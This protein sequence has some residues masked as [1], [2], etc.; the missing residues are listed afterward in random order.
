MDLDNPKTRSTQK[1][2]PHPPGVCD[3]GFIAS[4]VG[5]VELKKAFVVYV[6]G[7]TSWNHDHKSSN[8]RYSDGY[9]S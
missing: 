7:N 9:Q 6:L 2:P 8:E 3:F 1:P 4:L 5:T